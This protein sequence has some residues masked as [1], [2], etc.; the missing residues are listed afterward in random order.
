MSGRSRVVPVPYFAQPTG[1]T[2]QSTCLKMMATYL[3]Q[4]VVMQS[5]GA[6]DRD[7]L[8]IWK[9]INEDPKRP[10]KV[11]NAHKNM[12]WWLERHFPTLIFDYSQTNDEARALESMV[13]FIDGGFPVMVAVSHIN[14]EG[15]IILVVGY[16]NYVPYVSSLDF[17]IVVHDP[18]GSF[19]P[20]LKS[21]LFGNKRWEG[22]RSLM[23]GRRA[24]AWPERA[25][26]GHRRQ[27]AASGRRVAR[28][29]LPA[30]G[31]PLDSVRT[32][33]KNARLPNCPAPNRQPPARPWSSC[34][35]SSRTTAPRRE[36]WSSPHSP[37]P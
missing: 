15:H 8:E 3:E 14:V 25:A 34:P 31:A 30:V 1:I 21:K 35:D 29:V 16:D 11:R 32:R 12:K 36:S 37:P 10:V 19:D 6:A 33:L 23:S 26:A 24:G 20:S 5:T 27:S 13:R 22:G 9:D 17:K 2:C 28:H 18:Y 7:I 4:S